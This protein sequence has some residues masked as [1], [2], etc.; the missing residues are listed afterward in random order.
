MRIETKHGIIEV[1]TTSEL[2]KDI[3]YDVA[4]KV[5]PDKIVVIKFTPLETNDV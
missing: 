3:D 5:A 2:P 1:I 4:V